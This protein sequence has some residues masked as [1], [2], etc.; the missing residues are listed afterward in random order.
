MQTMIVWHNNGI[1]NMKEEDYGYTEHVTTSAV[2]T[3]RDEYI[4]AGIKVSHIDVYPM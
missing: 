2:D 3:V 4:S 1:E